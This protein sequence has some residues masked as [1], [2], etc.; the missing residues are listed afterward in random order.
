MQKIHVTGGYRCGTT[1]MRSLMVCF[2]GT[3]VYPHGNEPTI[4]HDAEYVVTKCGV[5]LV[6]WENW[7]KDPDLKVVCMLR[8]PR[9][10]SCSVEAGHPEKRFLDLRPEMVAHFQV[11]YREVPGRI[12]LIKY[13]DLVSDPNA[14]QK[15][16]AEEFG[17]RIKYS[18]TEGYKYF[19][20]GSDSGSLKSSSRGGTK[21]ERPIDAKSVGIW[22]SHPTLRAR[23]EQFGEE[24]VTKE[25]LRK[26]YGLNL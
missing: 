13:E 17:L 10:V 21:E 6:R 19:P 20:R 4:S 9:D 15:R 1:L 3:W 14:V 7:M 22:K 2:E 12:I 25:F 8:D 23:A 16:V 24:T 18:F 5:S 26:Y 11:D